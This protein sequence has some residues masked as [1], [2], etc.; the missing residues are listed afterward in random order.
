MVARAPLWLSTGLLVTGTRN[1]EILARKTKAV[2]RAHK[3]QSTSPIVSGL[4]EGISY[5]AQSQIL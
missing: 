1:I 4:Q 2:I 5:F 3:T